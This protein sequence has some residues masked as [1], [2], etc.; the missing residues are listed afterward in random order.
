MYPEL[1]EKADYML[2]EAKRAGIPEELQIFSF[3]KEYR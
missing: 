1:I 2:Y 3:S